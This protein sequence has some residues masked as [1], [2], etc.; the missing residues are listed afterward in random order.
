MISSEHKFA[1]PPP[2]TGRLRVCSVCGDR[3]IKGTEDRSN[4]SSVCN[5]RAVV[6]PGCETEYEPYQ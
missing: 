5:G 2:G 1:P 4:P 3:E 6:D